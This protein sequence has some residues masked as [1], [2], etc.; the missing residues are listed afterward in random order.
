MAIKME[1]VKKKKK[2]MKYELLIENR[3]LKKLLKEERDLNKKLLE[4]IRKSSNIKKHAV[5]QTPINNDTNRNK[6]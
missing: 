5:M 1:Q 3:E 6:N 4:I 2:I